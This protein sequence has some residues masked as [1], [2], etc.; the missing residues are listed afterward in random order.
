M[1]DDKDVQKL[2]E[3]QKKVFATKQDL[4]GLKEVFA[5]KQD[6]D[7]LKEVF[8][9]KQDIENLIDIVA[10]KEEMNNIGKDVK[11]IKSLLIDFGGRTR[12]LENKVDYIENTLNIS[13]LHTKKI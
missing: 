13:A 9:T 8:A 11:E 10:T 1:L 7:G 3:A 5:T 2:I 6:L 12:I 4:D